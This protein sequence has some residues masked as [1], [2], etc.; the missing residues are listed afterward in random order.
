MATNGEQT[1]ITDHYSVT[2]PAAIRDRLDIEPG[3]KITWKVTDDGE[4]TI[5]VIKQRYGAFDDF[6]AVDMGETDVT[7]EHDVTGADHDSTEVQ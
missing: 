3:D 7:R 2:V 6:D 5:E 1:T 4:L